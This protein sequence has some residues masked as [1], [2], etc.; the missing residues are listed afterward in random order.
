MAGDSTRTP[1][2]DAVPLAVAEPGVA[3]TAAEERVS[4]ASNWTLVWWRFR[5]HRLAMASAAVLLGFYAVVLCPDFFST[6]DP[7]LTD[8]RLAFIP[9][10]RPRLFDGFGWSPWVPAVV[11]KRNPIT[12]RME[13]QVDPARKIGVRFFVRGYPYRVFGL[14]P[15]TLHLMGTGEGGTDRV[16]LLGTDRLGRDQWSR[17]MHGT[18]TSMTIGLVAVTL[19][20]VLG[21]VLGGVSGYFGGMADQ[22]IQ[23][24]IELLQSLPTIPIWLALTAALPRDWTP[25]QVFFAIT[26]I[27]SL[28]G[29]TT[30]G[31]EV[32]GRFLAL[33]EEDFVLAAELAGCGR[34][35]I[36]MRHMVPTFLSHIIATSTLAIPAMILNETSLSFL[37]LGIRPPA[38]S[39][40]V[41]LQEAQN[42]QTLALAP[43]L[44]IPGLVVIVS[45]L[46]FNLV[47]DGLRDAADPYSH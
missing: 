38:I 28:V 45:V 35:R 22:V 19:S 16:H 4:L 8:A 1:V 43:W 36:I 46:A 41:L 47:G 11:G 12:L 30:L 42:I 33:R 9:V 2:P 18:Q 14:L 21:V 23:R 6:Q 3:P 44:L 27:L 40:G 31:R 5:K 37:G 25:I 29:W 24:V 26:V 17:L 15:T 34:P 13:W 20:V 32:R 7:E 10:Q 39:W